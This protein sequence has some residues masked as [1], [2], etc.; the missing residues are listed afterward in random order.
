VSAAQTQQTRPAIAAGHRLDADS[1]G[2]G[3]ERLYR[4][5]YALC[6]SRR[7]AED[8]VRSVFDRALRGPRFLRRDADLVYLV[9]ALCDVWAG[10]EPRAALSD[11]VDEPGDGVLGALRA[12]S[13]PLRETLVAVDVVGLSYGEAARALG[14][15]ERTIIDRLYRGREQIAGRLQS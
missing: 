12:L 7:V 4:G 1:L 14:T 15:S 8:L 10:L 11:S 6:G 13:R 3:V 9:R 2:S 5:A